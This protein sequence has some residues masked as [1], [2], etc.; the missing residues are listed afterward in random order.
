MPYGVNFDSIVYQMKGIIGSSSIWIDGLD[1]ICV[2]Y[3]VY[4]GLQFLRDTRAMQLIKGIGLLLAV[5]FISLVIDFKALRFIMQNVVNFGLFAL[6]IVFQPELRRVLEQ[7]GR[8]KISDLSVFGSNF[9]T[10]DPD[11]FA[12]KWGEAIEQIADAVDSLAKQ[13]IGGLI[14]I[15]R[16]TRLGDI[17]KT[18][19]VTNS[20][21]SA[22]L[23][24]NIF[25]PNSPLH[26]GALVIRDARLLAAGCFLPLSDNIEISK[27]LGTRHRAALGMSENSDAI[28]IVISEETGIVSVAING[29]LERNLTLK[30]LAALLLDELM[31]KVEHQSRLQTLLK[32]KSD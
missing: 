7:V 6:I 2:A 5:Y 21:V 15:E 27:Q 16:Q 28:I 3:L 24:C 8:T 17:V 23:I 12:V 10:N 4:K 14:V 13:T 31:P 20:D 32:R 1:I 22:S 18:G 9:N 26:D 29:R 25:F 30:S 19:T 11:R